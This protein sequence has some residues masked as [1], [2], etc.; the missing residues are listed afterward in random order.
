MATLPPGLTEA[1]ILGVR[2]TGGEAL[3]NLSSNFYRCCQSFSAEEEQRLIYSMVNALT[4]LEA[5]NR[6][7]FYV[8]AEPIDT[9]VTSV[10]LRGPLLRNPG[11]IEGAK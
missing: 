3:V 9:M 5:V 10:Y 1:D 6:V 4:E 11:I 7:R 2:V 8:E